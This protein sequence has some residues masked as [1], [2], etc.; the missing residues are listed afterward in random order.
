MYPSMI[1]DN[2][3]LNINKELNE[4]IDEYDKLILDNPN[5]VKRYKE[6]SE[7]EESERVN[8]R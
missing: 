3:F 6:E 5:E 1:K 2:D 4:A 7:R 8:R